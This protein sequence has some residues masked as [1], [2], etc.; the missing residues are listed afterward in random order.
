MPNPTVAVWPQGIGDSAVT[1]AQSQSAAYLNAPPQSGLGAGHPFGVAAVRF[2]LLSD[3]PPCECDFCRNAP[4]FRLQWAG[5]TAW[6]CDRCDKYFWGKVRRS[7][8][9]TRAALR[10]AQAPKGQ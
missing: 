7:R 1:L 3:P 8:T 6:L 2:K 4:A 5:R 10:R 9:A